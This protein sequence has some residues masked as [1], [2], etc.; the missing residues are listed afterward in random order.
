MQIREKKSLKDVILLSIL[1]LLLQYGYIDLLFN[2]KIINYVQYIGVLFACFITTTILISNKK[3]K[4]HKVVGLVFI[5]TIWIIFTS[6]YSISEIYSRQK[7]INYFIGIIY[8]LIGYVVCIANYKNNIISNL[9]NFTI[10][11]NTV[12]ICIYILININYILNSVLLGNRVGNESINPIWI[13]RICCET[14]MYILTFSKMGK[15]SYISMCMIF[16]LAIVTGSK[17]PIIS[18]IVAFIYYLF[19]MNNSKIDNTILLKK[20]IYII[21]VSLVLGIIIFNVFGGSEFIKNRFTI[22]SI[23][24]N[25]EGYRVNRY[26]RTWEMIKDNILI[27]NGFGSWPVLYSGIDKID[28]PHNIILELWSETG[29][30]GLGLFTS[31][32]MYAIKKIKNSSR[33]FNAISSIFIMNLVM[34]MFS[35]SI[36]EGNRSIY[37]YLGIICAMRVFEKSKHKN[38]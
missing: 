34:A 14:I 5:F 20:L 21:I 12:I 24:I 7:I 37:T 26:F 13:A 35:G 19:K 33:E 30:I 6:T 15:S 1:Y 32:I 27:G 10:K 17:G 29:I 4:I 18:L 8:F 11:I 22:E 25:A 31:I 38:Y 2:S 9:A 28:Y 3:I 36:A 16:S 23:F